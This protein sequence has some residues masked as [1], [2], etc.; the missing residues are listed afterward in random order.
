[1]NSFF[2][3][4]T[5]L[6]Q[7]RRREH[8]IQEEL[9]FHLAEETEER[10]AAGLEKDQAAWAA[11]RD[12]GNATLVKEST[13]EVWTWLFLEQLAQDARYALRGF[14][15]NPGFAV[16]AILS[17]AL[18]IGSSLAIYTVA[19]NLLLR[20]L[21]YAHASQLAMLWEESPRQHFLH[22]FVAP[23]NYFAFAARNNVFQDMA[24]FV[25]SQSVF[26]DN[27]RAEE[28]SE[29]VA[30]PNLLPLLGV[31]PVLGHRFS[32]AGKRAGSEPSILIS[33]RL[34]QSWFGGDTHIIGKHVQLG[35]RL[36]A[37][38]GVLPA[39]FSFQDRHIDVWSPLEISPAE[40]DGEG[41]WLL[42][43]ARLK[44]GVTLQQAQSELSA[45][46]GRNALDDPGLNKGW[47]ATV[48]SLRDALV[49][50]VKPSLLV[51]LAAVG[52]LLAVACANVASLLLA[53]YTA[54]HREIALRASLGAG[55]F[56][57][58]RQLLTES[59]LLAF[60]GGALGMLLARFAVLA[61]VSL[62][63]E[64]L[65]Q[66][67]EVVIDMRTY[68]FAAGLAA[69]TS[70]LFGLAPAFAGTRGALARNLQT[71]SRSSVGVKG[72]LRAWFVGAEI[73]LSVIL[74]S[75]ALLLFR[76]LDALQN[77]NPGIK[78]DNLLTLRVSL[79]GAQYSKP[80]Q[81]IQFFERAAHGIESLPGVRSASAIS[82]LPYNGMSPGTFVLIAGRPKR[83]PG[84]DLVATIR[85]ILPGYFHTMGIPII[86]GRDFTRADDRE[87]TPH[88]FV[89]SEAF[90]RKYLADVNPLDQQISVWMENDNPFGQII[91]VVADVKDQTLDQ[92]PTPTVYYP[93]A[94]LAYNRMV[95]VVRTATN[96]LGQA[97]A[98]RRVIRRIDPA[99]PIADVR[100]METVIADTFSRQ[101]FSTLLLAGFSS[102][103]LL[104]AAIGIY[105]ILT[106]AVS[107]RT[108]EIGLRVALG[109]TPRR[110][111]SL[112]IRAA[113]RPVLSGFFIGITGA[114]ALTGLL[115][116]L[117]F[118]ISPRDPFTF[119][120][121]PAILGFVA[122]IA[123]FLPARRASRL[124]PMSALRRE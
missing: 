90:V 120:A 4:L 101:H 53:R 58:V 110:V 108:R 124:D 5:W 80:S 35:G 20:P 114:L 71:D 103:S 41:R 21:P 77:V 92:A 89:V 38:V 106:Y 123:A 119:I 10:Q 17:L 23:R 85:T 54:R 87:D 83:K 107:E 65:T 48:E 97:E 24:A 16:T 6:L 15:D 113:A 81:S 122:L 29:L 66:S 42:C 3:K 84:D 86:S 63:P 79:P 26:A 76:S 7:R 60:M 69:L 32:D 94:H 62:A 31:E 96:P 67:I 98:I 1:M 40:N 19:D 109:A 46:A 13:R 12:L 99:Q 11:R 104:L 37:I 47:T 49:R 8:E 118:D 95:L 33:Y 93:H 43:V 91:G 9:Q 68:L 74:L 105:G 102:A 25:T 51:L 73:S 111:M 121:A 56:R 14:K 72:N 82:H 57:V 36:R 61:L 112:I 116:S 44:P 78:A 45:I 75:G 59:L 30:A 70:V 2:R 28:L 88:R 117:L 100:T 50:N 18:G 22:G 52:L 34:W 39:H 115:R 27:G 55:R 64:E